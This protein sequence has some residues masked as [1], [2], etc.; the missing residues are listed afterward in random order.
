MSS[1]VLKVL[2]LAVAHV[3]P[4]QLVTDCWP[5]TNTSDTVLRCVRPVPVATACTCCCH[6]LPPLVTTSSLHSVGRC[7]QCRMIRIAWLFRW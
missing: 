7:V 6:L 2:I 5:D 3:P 4:H 1:N